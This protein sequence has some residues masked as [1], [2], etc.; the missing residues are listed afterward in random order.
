M[1]DQRRQLEVNGAPRPA[2]PRS[3]PR[4]GAARAAD[5]ANIIATKGRRACHGRHATPSAKS[6]LERVGG[7]G[8][9]FA[10]KWPQGAASPPLR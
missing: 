10:L 2:I 6:W 7:T 8:P 3:P 1:T 4:I 5:A 9:N